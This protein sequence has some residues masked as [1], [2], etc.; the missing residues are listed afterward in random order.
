MMK[1]MNRW[2]LLVG[3][4]AWIVAWRIAGPPSRRRRTRFL[5]GLLSLKETKDT[6]WQD[7]PGLG[8]PQTY[9]GQLQ[10]DSGDPLVFYPNRSQASG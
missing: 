5:K 6:A 2:Y 4:A 9:T 1:S 3:A 7:D 8:E 10:R